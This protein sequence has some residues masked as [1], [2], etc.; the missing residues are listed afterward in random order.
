MPTGIP[1]ETAVFERPRAPALFDNPMRTSLLMILAVLGESYPAALGRYL[2]A[3]ISS[4]QRS[5][6]RLEAEG[7]IASRQIAVRN[8]TLNPLYPAAKELKALLLRLADGYP[9]YARIAESIRRR[10][11]RRRKSLI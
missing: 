11:R 1:S 6:D 5:L 4:V 3:T 7:L 8:V 10:P 9:E 2:G